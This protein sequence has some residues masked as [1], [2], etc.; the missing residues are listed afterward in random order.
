MRRRAVSGLVDVDRVLTL[1]GGDVEADT[2][3]AASLGDH[4]PRMGDVS[5]LAVTFV[6]AE[7]HVVDGPSLIVEPVDGDTRR[8]VIDERHHGLSIP[9]QRAEL[10]LLRARDAAYPT[11]WPI[12]SGDGQ[13]S[14]RFGAR[15]R[16][17]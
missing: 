11:R 1:R 2:A 7:V 13:L 6:G 3:L 5:G 12:I 15:T 17:G 10:D 4:Q 14:H 8:A 16:F 9:G